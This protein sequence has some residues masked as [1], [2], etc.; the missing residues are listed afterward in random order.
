MRSH[1]THSISYTKIKHTAPHYVSKFLVSPIFPNIQSPQRLAR[2]YS[3]QYEYARRRTRVE[4]LSCRRP[5]WSSSSVLFRRI[6][7][8]ANHGVQQCSCES[9]SSLLSLLRTLG[10][11]TPW[12][13]S[14]YFSTLKCAFRFPPPADNLKYI[15]ARSKL[16]FAPFPP[17]T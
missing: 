13:N 4:R 11:G 6:H 14:R 10:A 16:L 3:I 1:H 7:T 9:T 2:I 17:S 5:R 8:V 15:I 12:P